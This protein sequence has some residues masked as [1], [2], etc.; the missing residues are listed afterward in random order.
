MQLNPSDPLAFVPYAAFL[1]RVGRHEE[2]LT[3][4]RRA[5]ELDPLSPFVSANVILYA[6]RILGID[7][8]GAFRSL[9]G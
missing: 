8:G 7:A 6:G 1:N 3:M 5:E 2:A 4:I 9:F